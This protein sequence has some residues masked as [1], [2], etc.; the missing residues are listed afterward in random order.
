M[1]FVVVC[2]KLLYCMF[3]SDLCCIAHEHEWHCVLH[4]VI[5]QLK[6]FIKMSLNVL[7]WKPLEKT[8]NTQFPHDL[9]RF[10]QMLPFV[11]KDIFI[12]GAFQLM[13]V[14][15]LII[16]LTCL[17]FMLHNL[18]FHDTPRIWSTH[19][20]LWPALNVMP[21]STRGHFMVYIIFADLSHP[22]MQQ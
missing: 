2:S 20:W 4:F 8:W 21:N 3:R 7:G 15:Y 17:R 14:L 13:K 10:R 18:V 9:F 12:R 22:E 6:H 16:P 1:H 19:I 11:W 5:I